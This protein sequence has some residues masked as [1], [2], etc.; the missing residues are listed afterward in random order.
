MIVDVLIG[1]LS[2]AGSPLLRFLWS[3]HMAQR[4]FLQSAVVAVAVL[5]A[6]AAIRVAVEPRMGPLNVVRVPDNERSHVGE[7]LTASVVDRS[8]LLSQL[9][10]KR[11]LLMG[12][13]HFQQEPQAWLQTLLFDLHAKDGRGAVLLLELPRHI[14]RQIDV[15]L[16]T[17]DES[18]LDKAFKGSDVLPYKSTVRW[19]RAHPEVVKTIL[20]DDENSWHIGL[21]RL[22]LTDT[23]NDTMA[24]AIAVA[25][26][27][28]PGQRIVAYGGRMHMMNSGR[29]MY[30]SNTRRPIG[31]RLPAMG[32]AREDTSAVW[33]FAGDAP[34]DGIW[35][36]QNTVTFGGP[37]GDLPITKLEDKPIFGAIR[38]NEVA[39][40]AVQL[41][42]AT[43]IDNQ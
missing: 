14:Q 13:E 6:L 9:V 28:H 26:N 35:D 17:G 20:A 38:L 30:D 39:D 10:K 31:A 25:V 3:L 36:K 1:R 18:A 8:A 23:R 33:L 4:N 21:M 37:A 12:E 41:G 27:T 42:P 7:V 16:A 29:Y 43:P 2:V 19:A 24:R 32:V 34:F 5:T 22:L 40:Y 15:Y 11:V